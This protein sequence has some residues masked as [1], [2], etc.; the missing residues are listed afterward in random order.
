MKSITS[1]LARLRSLE[2]VARPLPTEM[3]H[4]QQQARVPALLWLTY[5]AF[6]VIGS[7][8]A[9]RRFVWLLLGAVSLLGLT[10]ALG[11]DLSWQSLVMGGLIGAVSFKAW[12]Q[13]TLWLGTEA[14]EDADECRR[15]S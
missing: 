3:R 15:S 11:I 7:L 9:G 13:E 5:R 14:R 12:H 2:V 4:W 10:Q 8:P 6:C 1:K